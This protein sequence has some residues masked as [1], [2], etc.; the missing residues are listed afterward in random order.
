MKFKQYAPVLIPTL[1]RYEHFKR[2]LESLEKCKDAEHTDVYIALDYP[3]SDKYIEGWKKIDTYL[4]EKEKKNGFNRLIVYRREMNYFFSGKG[5]LKTAINDLS[6]DI[7]FYIVTEDDN[8]FS[9][10]FL[11]FMNQ[12]KEKY[13]KSP[14]VLSVC[15]YNQENFYVKDRN[16]I[17]VYDT[18]AWG[19]GRWRHKGFPQENYLSCVLR[20]PRKIIKLWKT[21]PILLQLILSLVRQKKLYGDASYTAMCIC[22]DKYQIR[23]SMSFVRN[24]GNDGS[25]L[26]SGVSAQFCA[27]PISKELEVNLPDVPIERTRELDRAVYNNMMPNSLIHRG[28]VHLKI[29]VGLI[30]NVFTGK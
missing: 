26:H 14:Q 21:Y 10:C 16:V 3:P 28:I 15:G 2:C 17:F 11:D 23:P 30:L 5:N 18:S 9:P 6:N 19:I 13:D 20:S 22:E 29:F 4:V 12:A 7:D 24:W 1:N 8:E 25:G 27:Q